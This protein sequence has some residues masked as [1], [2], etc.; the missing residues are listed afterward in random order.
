[1]TYLTTKSILDRALSRVRDTSDTLRLKMLGWLN[2][3]MQDLINEPRDWTFLERT[4]TLPLTSNALTLPADF[5][6]EVTVR[7]GNY[8]LTT[9][10]RLSAPDAAYLDEAGGDPAGYTVSA[11]TLTIHPAATGTADLTYTAQFPATDYADD[12]SDTLFPREF[13][14]LFERA[15]VAQFYEYDVDNERMGLGAGI[16]AELA[17]K[18]K[19]LDNSRKPSPQL[20]YRGFPR[21]RV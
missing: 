17:R 4:V 20:D 12:T 19:A 10:D 18:A 13:L 7:T 6:R 21:T 3:A 5:N 9:N 15:M 14:P 1:M 2:S 16:Y 8:L 11:T